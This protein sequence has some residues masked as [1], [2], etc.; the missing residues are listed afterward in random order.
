MFI[1][2]NGFKI[3]CGKSL[4]KRLILL[5]KNSTKSSYYPD[6]WTSSNIILAHKKNDKQLLN[7]FS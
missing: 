4:L 2:I 5:F 3:K 6:I 7:N 1:R